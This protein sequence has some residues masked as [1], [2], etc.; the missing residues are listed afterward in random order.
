MNNIAASNRT[1]FEEFVRAELGDIPVTDNGRYISGKI[2]NLWRTWNEA[3]RRPTQQW[4]C[5]ETAP[6][7]NERLLVL[8]RF[9]DE[10]ELVELDWDGV[11]EYW[12]ESWEMPH[13]NGY[14][15]MSTNGISEPTHWAYQD[16]PL[17]PLDNKAA[18]HTAR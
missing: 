8:A 2:N 4:G 11:W 10:G 17:P 9:N 12:E 5:I 3:Q 7:D 1:A 18:R 6:T 15:W 14:T 16:L 13:I